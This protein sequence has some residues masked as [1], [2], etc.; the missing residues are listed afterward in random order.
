VARPA[1]TSSL[2]PGLDPLPGVRAAGEGNRGQKRPRRPRGRSTAPR[3]KPLKPTRP[4]RSVA[5]RSA[6]SP[7][8]RTA[9][10]S[11][12]APKRRVAHYPEASSAAALPRPGPG[13]GTPVTCGP[14]RPPRRPGGRHATRGHRPLA[15]ARVDPRPARHVAPCADRHSVPPRRASPPEAGARARARGDRAR[16]GKPS[17]PGRATRARA[18]APWRGAGTARRGSTTRTFSG[19]SAGRRRCPDPPTN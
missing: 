2:A 13:H 16:A 4:P 9:S 6:A 17:L 18:P 5:P 7:A 14:P 3:V 19:S 8:T 10:S 15:A 11:L 12:G 1:A